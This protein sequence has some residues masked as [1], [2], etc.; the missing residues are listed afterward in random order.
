MIR[1]SNTSSL[2][3]KYSILVFFSL[4]DFILLFIFLKLEMNTRIV[5]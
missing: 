1:Y 3:N 2:N 4:K 5:I